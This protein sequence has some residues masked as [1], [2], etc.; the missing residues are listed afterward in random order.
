MGVKCLLK[1]INE[2]PELIQ[3]V[4]NSKYKFKRIA[5]DISILIYKIIITVRNSGADYINQKGEIT[6]HILGLFNKTIELLNDYFTNRSQ[7]LKINSILSAVSKILL[8]IPQRNA[9]SPLLF[10]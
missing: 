7:Y 8:E 5:V 2:I 3:N 6:T 9:L 10:F 1:F 4:D